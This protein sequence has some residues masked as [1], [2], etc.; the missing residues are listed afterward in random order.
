[1]EGA[2]NLVEQPAESTEV[3]EKVLQLLAK[4]EH[5]VLEHPPCKTSE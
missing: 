4:A 2:S 3:F 1:M 5:K